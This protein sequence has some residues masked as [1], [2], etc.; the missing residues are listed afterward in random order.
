MQYIVEIRVNRGEF[1]GSMT[2]MRTWFDHQ[3]IE[4]QG[5]RHATS[6]FTVK[7]RVEFGIESQA[8]AFA[9]AFSGSLLGLPADVPDAVDAAENYAQ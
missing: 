1:I 2:D 4:P 8:T 9:Q 7:F 5:F 6:G 3:R